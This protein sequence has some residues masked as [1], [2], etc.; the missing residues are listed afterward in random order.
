[1]TGSEADG[2]DVRRDIFVGL[3]AD[4]SLARGEPSDVYIALS[5]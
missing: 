5:L 4:D 2:E 1:M 3:R